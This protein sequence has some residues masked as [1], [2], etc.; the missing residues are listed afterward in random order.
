MLKIPITKNY[1]NW[2]Q[3]IV[4]QC[5]RFL[6][7]GNLKTSSSRTI[8]CLVGKN[9][10]NNFRNYY[11]V[12]KTADSSIRLVDPTSTLSF[13]N[14]VDSDVFILVWCLPWPA[15]IDGGV[16]LHILGIKSNNYIFWGNEEKKA[17]N[18]LRKISMYY[19]T[20]MQ[21]RLHVMINSNSRP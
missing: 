11:F 5:F 19:F 7:I 15:N 4:V 20:I 1:I 21:K 3:T 9:Y 6:F 14:I 8:F 18:K 16:R 2:K 10:K 17:S 12:S 13:P